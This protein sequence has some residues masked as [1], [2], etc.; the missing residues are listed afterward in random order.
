[1]LFSSL[2]TDDACKDATRLNAQS[3]SREEGVRTLDSADV[4][5]GNVTL[6]YTC[7]NELLAVAHGQV[8]VPLVP[9]LSG[10]RHIE[11]RLSKGI[12]NLIAY[13]ETVKADAWTNL[14]H[15]IRWMCAIDFCHLV[16]GFLDDALHS[17][18]PSGMN[19]TDGMMY[20]VIE[21][22]RNAV[23]C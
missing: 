3:T 12:V 21:Q 8:D 16:D 2:F 13:L 6:C 23:S 15:D 18:S 5:D 20:W 9:T 1:M 10:G 17:A 4:A 22:H 7:S 11:P 19:G 14:G